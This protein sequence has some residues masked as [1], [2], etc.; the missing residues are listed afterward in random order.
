MNVILVSDSFYSAKGTVD[1]L[2]TLLASK[3]SKRNFV[4]SLYA[5]IIKTLYVLMISLFIL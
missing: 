4:V 3:L 2:E 5:N 1:I